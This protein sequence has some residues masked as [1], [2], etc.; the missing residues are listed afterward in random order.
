MFNSVT[1]L[2]LLNPG[3]EV[4]VETPMSPPA[5]ALLE[6]QLIDS[7]AVAAREYFAKY[8]DER[9][10]LLCVER[11]GG[12]DGPDDAIENV[13]DWPLLHALGADDDVRQ[14]VEKAW[15]GHLRQYTSA[16][17]VEVP[18]ARDGMYYKEFPTQFDWMHNGE[19]LAVFNL[20]GL[21]N[22][23]PDAFEQRVRRYAGFY[24][25]EDPG[26]PNYDPRH[27][28]IRSLFNGSRGPLL[29]KTTALDWAG[30]PIEVANRFH[31]GHGER[32]YD[33]MLAHFKDYNDVVGDHPQNLRATTL[34][35]NAFALTHE[36]KYKRWLLE[37]VDAW[38]ERAKDN[39]GIMPSN[40]GLD[41]MIG[42]A[43]EG[44]WYGGVYGWGF[45][46]VVPQ[47]GEL[48]HRTRTAS[49]FA[50]LM[51]A[52]LVTGDDRYLDV[53]RT[54]CD[55]INAAAKS[56][57]GELKYPRMYGDDGWYDWQATPYAE[58]AL[59]MYC[60]SMRGD[61]RARVLK[62]PWLDYLNGKN[63]KYPETALRRDL[64]EIRKRMAA[65]RLDA[66]TPDTRL[67]DDP[68]K[69]N[70]AQIESLLHL[71]MGCP[72]PGRG[73]NIIGARLRYFDA[74]RR[75]AG[76]P[77]DVSALVT[78]MSADE[79]KLTLV[80][81]GQVEARTV[82]VQAGAY[83]E[84]QI[85]GITLADGTTYDAGSPTVAVRLAPGCGGELTIRHRRYANP[86]TLSQPF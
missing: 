69:Y 14:M 1:L 10:W 12:D 50:G 4:V 11:W 21:S 63:E 25:N 52:V 36:E 77:R 47:T 37:Y 53:W 71:A 49:G 40:I 19:G 29:R 78:A 81:V 35:F 75:R 15:E 61:D 13:N 41:G 86:P 38:R 64:E 55:K 43:T 66:T 5:W 79:T 83:G 80:N 9:G 62:N 22:P 42:G 31:P 18:L 23:R 46:V 67:S 6:R 68:Y 26:A 3:A 48:A 45:S 34:A 30:D 20:M 85:T 72:H 74:D 32:S 51:N 70:P 27:K 73:G 39:G 84:H 28:I 60:L 59:E 56:I 7:A 44:K 2:L 65:M 8:F 33:E 82:V 76:L 54:Q 16:K 17:T 58:H 57:D 24:M